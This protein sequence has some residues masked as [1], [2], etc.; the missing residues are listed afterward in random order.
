MFSYDNPNLMWVILLVSTKIRPVREV[1]LSCKIDLKEPSQ[2]LISGEVSKKLHLHHLICHWKA[3]K[4]FQWMLFFIPFV[5]TWIM[6][7]KQLPVIHC[8]DNYQCQYQNIHFVHILVKLVFS[9]TTHFKR[10]MCKINEE[11]RL[12]IKPLCYKSKAQTHFGKPS[13][14]VC[15]LSKP[16]L[17]RLSWIFT[18]GN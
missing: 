4:I 14:P 10:Y 13:V 2:S 7:H 11:K 12:H 3:V 6:T 17:K 9:S 15:Y 1:L 8:H 16:H 5:L 18:K